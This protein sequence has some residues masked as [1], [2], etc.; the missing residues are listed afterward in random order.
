MERCPAPKE[1]SNKNRFVLHENKLTKIP[2]NLISF[3]FSPLF[4]FISKIR[5]LR[6]PFIKSH[7]EKYFSF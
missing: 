4:S 3:I 1:S 6:E 5:I 7:K 2:L